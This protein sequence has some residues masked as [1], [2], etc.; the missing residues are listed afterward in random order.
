MNIRVILV[1]DHTILRQGMRLLLDLQEDIE[2]VGEEGDG[3]NALRLIGE[4]IPDV[5]ILD[6]AMP[7]L[8]GL[9]ILT[10]CKTQ[11]QAVKILLLTQYENKEYVLPAIQAGA[12]GYI[13][14][15]SAADELVTA[16]RQVNEGKRYL[17]P[18]IVPIVMERLQEKDDKVQKEDL[19]E[20]EK[21]VLILLAQG[22]TLKEVAQQLF[23]SSKTVEFHRGNAFRK[24][25][26]QNR[27]DLVKYAVKKGW[28]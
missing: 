2:V 20:R 3:E 13:I 25:G 27:S 8:N 16:I 15:R 10:L 12:D 5:V 4:L 17:S 6:L 23:I 21:E 18:D 26:F 7:G 9:E 14:K 22:L 24:L 19:S 11:F 1:D 28:V